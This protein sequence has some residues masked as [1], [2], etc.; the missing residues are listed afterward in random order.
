ML[1]VSQAVASLDA[2]VTVRSRGSDP[3]GSY[4]VSGGLPVGHSAAMAR[5]GSQYG[6]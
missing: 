2:Q 4:A 1:V 5:E 6:A 3:S